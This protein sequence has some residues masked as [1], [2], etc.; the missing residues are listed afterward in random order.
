MPKVSVRLVCLSPRWALSCDPHVQVNGGPPT[1]L[2]KAPVTFDLPDGPYEVV[3]HPWD[4]GWPGRG[5]GCAETG[6]ATG[7]D[8]IR[9]RFHPSFMKASIMRGH[10]WPDERDQR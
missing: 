1:R 9:Y 7:D 6:V 10:L 8:H 4:E 5:R 2:T 3:V